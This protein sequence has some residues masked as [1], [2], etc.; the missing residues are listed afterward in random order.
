MPRGRPPN[1]ERRRQLAALLAEGLSQSEVAERLGVT[2]QAVSIFL[3]GKRRRPADFHVRCRECGQDLNPIAARTEHDRKAFCPA[4][5]EKHPEASFAEYLTCYRLVAGLSQTALAARAGI[6]RR[7][8]TKL[9]CGRAQL[10][11][12][13]RAVPGAGRAAGLR[14]EASGE[15]ERFGVPIARERQRWTGTER[16]NSLTA[17]RCSRAALVWR[18]QNYF[19]MPT[20]F[21]N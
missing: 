5:L 9:E 14:S 3:R 15:T 8:V 18:L 20:F 13:G 12:R 21:K 7:I 4:C 19:I 17:F 10:E 2:K 1:L 6:A 11:E 16:R